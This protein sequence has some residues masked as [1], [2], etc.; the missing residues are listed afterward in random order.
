M[1]I[2]EFLN[3]DLCDY[4]TYSTVRQIASYIDGLK[5]SSRKVVF[6]LL[7]QKITNKLKVLQLSNKCAEY[8]DYLHGSLDG[9]VV[10]LGA[11]YT[12]ANNINLVEPSGN[13]GTR[14]APEASAPR[15]IFGC[16]S[17]NLFKLFDYDDSA[18]LTYQ[19]FEGNR[20]EPKF[21]V[22]NLPLLLVNGSTGLA[23]GFRQDILPRDPENLKKYC[24]K[25]V[26]GTL[27]KKD[28]KLLHPFIKGFTGTFIQDKINPL[29]YTVCGKIFRKDKTKLMVTEMP[30]G[31]DYISA[32]KHFDKL[33][34]N[35]VIDSYEDL[36]DTK[37]DTFTFEVKMRKSDLDRMSEDELLDKLRLKTTF[38]EILTTL[39]EN[40][41][42]RIFDS[43]PDLIKAYMEIKL[44][45]NQLRKEHI[46]D[47]LTADIDLNKSKYE[48]IKRIVDGTLVV[49]KRKKDDIIKDLDKIDIIIKKDD[50]YDYL[51]SMP[52]YSLTKERMD[53]LSDTIKDL[54]DQYNTVKVKTPEIIFTEDLAKI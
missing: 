4:G 10:S 21:Y 8:A 44:H 34:E 11:D 12:G 3:T 52:I 50:S 23:T 32:I 5:N 9:V 33:E 37:A 47:R 28:E 2:Q 27:T 36:C 18:V 13:F 46:L 25:Y 7:E 22:P 41:K 43:V 14:L 38:T 53:K 20:I 35:K 26:E 31:F 54:K 29:K 51:L 15:Y 48:F 45:Y 24:Q 39:D 19:T 40:L 42:I 16:A 6:T 30:I 1:K 49:Q 17:D